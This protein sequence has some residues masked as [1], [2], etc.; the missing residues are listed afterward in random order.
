MYPPNEVEQLQIGGKQLKIYVKQL[1]IY[2][3]HFTFS[4]YHPPNTLAFPFVRSMM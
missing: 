3:L 4:P 2:G 1:N